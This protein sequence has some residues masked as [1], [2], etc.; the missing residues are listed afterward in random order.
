[1]K[2]SIKN[3]SMTYKTGKKA[4]NDISLEM[5][6]PNFIGLLGPNGAGKSTF[7]KLLISKIIPTAGEIIVDGRP[8]Q[9]YEKEL[10]NQLGYLPQSFG[11][12]DELTVY[13]FLDYMCALKEIKNNVKGI[14]GQAIERTDLQEKRNFK[15]KTLS[16]G[17]RQRVGIAQVLLG[18]P[19]LIILDEPTVG[20]D[21]EE[22]INFRNVFSQT[23]NDKI[24]LLS[25]H[26]IDDIQAICNRIIIINNGTILF[27]GTSPDLIKAV[28]GHVGFVE[29]K[30]NET[31]E[32]R[33]GG[34]YKI[35]SKLF[36]GNGIS[37]RVIGKEIES[38]IPLI[39]PTLED[40]YTYVIHNGGVH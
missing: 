25:T 16:G 3:V 31:L 14:I 8:I 15:I 13:E 17:Q 10:R 28:H 5:K 1:M 32:K 36:T 2:I 24:V 4:L 20:L 33:I 19:E 9:K 34:K 7:M 23:A 21:P 11:L 27:D 6:S 26:I 29:E 30:D 12:Y 39:E 35:T 37:C 22:R 40:A 18:N 38:S